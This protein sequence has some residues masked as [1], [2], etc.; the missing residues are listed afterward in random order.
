MCDSNFLFSLWY[1]PLE[2]YRCLCNALY[3][4][5]SITLYTMTNYVNTR[6]ISSLIVGV[7]FTFVACLVVL[8]RLWVRVKLIRFFGPE[9]ILVCFATILNIGFLI[10][11]GLQLEHGMGLHFDDIDSQSK[12]T[13]LQVGLVL[14]QLCSKRF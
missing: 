1:S 10:S 9:D 14:I 3:L 12:T 13:T 7:I 6:G 5:S 4:H 11:M 8:L 2:S